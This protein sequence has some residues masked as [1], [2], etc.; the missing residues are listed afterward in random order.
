MNPKEVVVIT[1]DVT[2]N[3]GNQALSVAWVNLVKSTFPS[4]R[5]RIFDRSPHYL[6]RFQL[7]D[8]D[9]LGTH[10]FATFEKIATEMAT[11]NTESV[12]PSPGKHAI[13]LDESV[14]QRLPLRRLRERVNIKRWLAKAGAFQQPYLARLAAIK[15]ADLVIINPA[16]E[17]FPSNPRPAFYHLLDAAIATKVGAKTAIV[18][19]TMDVNSATL[20]EI[21]PKLYK[22]LALVGF[23]DHKS[24]DSFAKMGGSPANVMVTPDLALTTPPTTA[25]GYRHK[26]VGV[27]IQVTEASKSNL[28]SQWIDLIR[29][30]KRAGY[31]PVLIS[32]EFPTDIDFLTRA[33]AETGVGIE[34]QQLGH[35]DYAALLGSFEVVVSSRMHTL[36]LGMTAGTPMVPVEGSSFKITGLFEEL[37]L[38]ISVI[39]PGSPGWIQNVVANVGRVASERQA[40][41]ALTVAQVSKASSQITRTVGDALKALV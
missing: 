19:H 23:R 29:E 8:L 13:R 10:T 28:L 5:V 1:R 41:S 9:H 14:R 32:N 4:A 30:L 16:G 40:L 37:Q 25:K 26:H 36:I 21:I 15:N 7:S 24:T 3:K 27:A 35:T 17:F 34:G 12:E 31:A 11:L 22:Q 2:N 6:Q 38:P 18:N 39:Q 20:T 33:A